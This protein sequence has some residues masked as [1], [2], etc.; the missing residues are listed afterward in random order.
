MINLLFVL[1]LATTSIHSLYSMDNEPKEQHKSADQSERKEKSNWPFSKK[2]SHSGEKITT[3][4][5]KQKDHFQKRSSLPSIHEGKILKS[6]PLEH[7][8]ITAVRKNNIN[9]VIFYLNNPYFNPN[10]QRTTPLHYAATFKFTEIINLFFLD[11][12]I[13]ASTRNMKGKTARELIVGT[14]DEDYALRRK[15]FARASLNMV[16][17]SHVD[18]IK[19]AYASGYIEQEI[20][21][22]TVEIIIKKAREDEQN[23]QADQKLP[24]AAHYPDYATPEFVEKMLLFRITLTDN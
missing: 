16:V 2:K 7:G 1:V 3:A 14:T 21:K 23:Q 8:L 17:N 4:Q 6:T 19:P 18:K 20:I 12:R 24:D 5:Q 22:K 11:P 15:F 13:D 9:G 10:L